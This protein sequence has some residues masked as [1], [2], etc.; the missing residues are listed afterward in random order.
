MG[1]KGQ[2]KKENMKDDTSESWFE[3]LSAISAYFNVLLCL[4]S[5]VL[6]P[7]ISM[8][9]RVY[10]PATHF[11]RLITPPVFRVTVVNANSSIRIPIR[12]PPRSR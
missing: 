7:L 2:H 3:L 1:K 6:H 8:F 10:F 12:F 5:E 9:Y 4:F 11:P